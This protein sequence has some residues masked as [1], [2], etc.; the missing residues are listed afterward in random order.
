MSGG[1]ILAAVEARAAAFSGRLGVWARSLTTGETVRWHADEVFPSA[2]AI[3]LPIL[4]E[5]FRQAGAGHLRLTDTRVVRAEDVV[6][7]SGILKDLTPPL[8]LS[9][10]DLAALMIVLS[11]N[12]A[13][14]VLIDVVGRDAVNASMRALGYGQ[15]VLD[16]PFF[17]AR[18]GAPM[19]RATPADLGGLMARIATHA[20]LTPAAC[21]EMLAI[22]RRQHHTDLITRRI[23]E[24]DGFV[25]EGAEPVVRVA[26]KS[27]AIRGTRNDV[28]LVERPGLRYVIAMMS[29]DCR[30]RRFYVDNEAAVLL[31][32]VS[33]LIYEHFCRA[34]GIHPSPGGAPA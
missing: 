18:P 23:A 9:L 30:D 10:R 33:G 24:F 28:A 25:D 3:K 29:A 32:D 7:G 27:G 19:N 21:E 12:T 1:G 16:H 5:V 2:S 14:N 13:A 31:A 15:T 20:V 4:Y 26:S 22:L 17:R 11:D 6:P 34:A 8:E